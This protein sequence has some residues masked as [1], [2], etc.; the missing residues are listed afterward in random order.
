[1]SNVRHLLRQPPP[2]TLFHYTTPAG[3]LGIVRGRE[4]WASHTQYL[5][6]QREFTHAVAI[7]EDEIAAMKHEA[8]YTD[9]RDMLDEMVSVLK[10]CETMNVCVCSFSERGDLL[11]QW[12]AYGG[13]SGFS[14]G[15]R[16]DFLRTI[17][18]GKEFW[19][20]KC[21]YDEPDQ[22]RV[23]R[24]LLDDVIRENE[25][26]D[27]D[28][29][30]I[31]GG[32]LAA[33]LNRYAPMLKHKS[34]E[35]EQEWRIISRPLACLFEEFDFRAGTSMLIPYYRMSLFTESEPFQIEQVI[36]GPTPNS[37][38]SWNS[39]QSLLVKHELT[40]TKVLNTAAPF[41]NW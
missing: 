14:V 11:S 4:I 5:N 16:G 40:H 2:P 15:F 24:A 32:N 19:L 21:I 22:R 10:D 41:R 20:A 8:Q 35:E 34:F 6:D 17:T 23:M 39:V 3:L 9:R 38:Q 33:Y 1:M 30:K 18:D 28:H 27:P 36:V 12:R 37:R 13:G 25:Q 26:R 31:P 7:I 29:R